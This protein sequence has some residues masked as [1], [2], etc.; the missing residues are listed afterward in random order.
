MIY[1]DN[2]AT[3]MVKPR[4]VIDAVASAMGSLGNPGRGAHGASLN[5]AR[6]IF[7]ARALL[8][9]FFHAENASRIA[10]TANSTESLNIAV[11][12]IL[13]PGDHVISTV[14]EHNSVLRPLYEMEDQGVEL[15]L[16]GCDEY[17][18]IRYEEFE[19]AIQNN[20]KA[21]ICTHG[22][23][24]T[25]NLTDIGKIGEIA[26]R[27]GLIF[28]VDAA[29][30]AGIFDI[31][32]Q[33]MNIDILC[34]TGHKGLLGPQGTG[35]IYVREGV[36]IRPLKTGGSGIRTYQKAHPGDMPEILEAGTLNGH[37][38]AG[39]FAAVSY[40][41]Q[42]G[43]EFIRA[44]EERLM[45]TFYNNISNIPEVHVYGDFQMERRCP[46][47]TFNIG[48]RDSSR[49][50]DEL[51]M[52][53]DIC[54]RAG[55]HC[56]PLMHRALKTDRQGAV[57]ISFSHYNTLEEAEKAAAAVRQLAGK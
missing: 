36:K 50:A 47:V 6:S 38:I 31:D 48:D 17:G 15:S 43:L 19:D 27:R 11:K 23:N 21:I 44:K 53:Y 18:A 57:R 22:S 2:A 39:L 52:D 8:A 41:C 42:T 10:F 16:L 4:E 51:F 12:G 29:Q 45:R 28:I 56:A 32:V 37:G 24:V 20:T 54:V 46:I 1:L 9:D 3:T 30:T 55:G 49:I 13:N 35:G 40:I 25:G 7:K 5:A 34:F 33:K 14:L 26:R